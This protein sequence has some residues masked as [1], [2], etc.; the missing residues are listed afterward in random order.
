MWSGWLTFQDLCYKPKWHLLSHS[1]MQPIA[2]CAA[3]Y[4][5]NT[6]CNASS[7]RAIPQVMRQRQPHGHMFTWGLVEIPIDSRACRYL[8]LFNG[9]VKMSAN[10]S[11]VDVNS[12]SQSSRA[13]A[14]DK[15]ATEIRCVLLRDLSFWLYPVLM[16]VTTEELSS[17]STDGTV[18]W[19]SS[20]TRCFKG[21]PSEKT[22]SD[23]ETISASVVLLL[24][25]DCFLAPP[26]YWKECSITG[27]EDYVVTTVTLAGDWISC[28]IRVCI[29]VNP[30]NFQWVWNKS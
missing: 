9:F 28:E 24:T 11:S 16:I 3:A 30:G 22:S 26:H 21:I 8:I 17:W 20:S 12:T 18:V 7:C 6:K 19:S 4:R 23:A 2:K 14:S 1:C 27:F 13:I 10:W 15:A 29:H 25:H 5:P